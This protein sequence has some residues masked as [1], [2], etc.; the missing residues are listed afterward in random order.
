MKKKIV[1]LLTVLSLL[2]A[3]LACG[4]TASA[5]EAPSYGDFTGGWYPVESLTPDRGTLTGR[6]VP[7][8]D[9]Y[10]PTEEDIAATEEM[11]REMLN[12]ILF[13]ED[14]EESELRELMWQDI[15]QG[16]F[17]QDISIDASTDAYRLVI[18]K[19]ISLEALGEVAFP[20]DAAIAQ[21]IDAIVEKSGD[22]VEWSAYDM[23]C[24]FLDFYGYDIT[25]LET[26]ADVKA[27]L[28]EIYPE[29]DIE[30]F[31]PYVFSY[32][33][34]LQGV[35]DGTVKFD[36]KLSGQDSTALPAWLEAYFNNMV[37]GEEAEMAAQLV[38]D[39]F[40]DF[41]DPQ[42]TVSVLVNGKELEADAESFEVPIAEGSNEVVFQ[43]KE[44]TSYPSDS[45]EETELDP[46]VTYLPGEVGN[47]ALIATYRI[48]IEV[49]PDGSSSEPDD[50]S[51]EEND[52]S[53]SKPDSS[54][55]TP[56]GSSST[57]APNTG[58]AGVAGL[59]VLALTAGAAVVVFRKKRG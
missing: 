51:K 23:M 59:V 55:S 54:S 4:F 52:P 1:V 48:A 42:I 41:E 21:A 12:M 6:F 5:Q 22:L 47:D 31:D 18:L 45:I 44:T 13:P 36:F 28:A 27:K 24:F 53:S 43:V 29:K 19:M 49:S 30:G 56:S 58:E 15:Q 25:S 3:M 50:S 7:D 9:Y 35:G 8:L 20:D 39:E 34:I 11:M 16:P 17:A 10:S 2:I 46:G 38:E 26:M 37:E 40:P 57:K 32:H 14:V 33:L